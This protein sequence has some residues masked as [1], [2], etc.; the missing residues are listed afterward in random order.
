MGALVEVWLVIFFCWRQEPGSDRGTVLRPRRGGEKDV[1]PGSS[2]AVLG[3]SEGCC[4]RPACLPCLG[5][6]REGPQEV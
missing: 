3:N 6:F 1:E 5:V 2:P 4:P